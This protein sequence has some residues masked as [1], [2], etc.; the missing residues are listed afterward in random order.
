MTMINGFWYCIIFEKNHMLIPKR[1]D[2]QQELFDKIV[3]KENNVHE[4]HH[5]I[6]VDQHLMKKPFDIEMR[7]LPFV[8]P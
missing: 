2:I 8:L 3:E 6:Y 5:S 4:S 7:Q 1:A